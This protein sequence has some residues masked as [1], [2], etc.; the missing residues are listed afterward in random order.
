MDPYYR[1]IRQDHRTEHE[2]WR[3]LPRGS[4]GCSSY[5]HGSQR[6]LVGPCTRST[7][8]KRSPIRQISSVAHTTVQF[9]LL[10]A[11]PCLAL[12]IKLKSGGNAPPLPALAASSFG[13]GGGI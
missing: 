12:I 11:P 5:P 1:H 9:G 7:T 8:R 6:Q 10:T 13:Y 3:L 4:M 2:P